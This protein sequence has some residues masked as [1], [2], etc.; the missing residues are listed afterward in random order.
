MEKELCFY[1]VH[2]YLARLHATGKLTDDEMRA[3]ADLL[4]QRRFAAGCVG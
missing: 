2:R 1:M 3:A 4:I